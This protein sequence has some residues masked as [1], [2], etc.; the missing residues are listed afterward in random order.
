MEDKNKNMDK[1]LFFKN[2]SYYRSHDADI[3][4][5]RENE[6]EFLVNCCGFSTY[7]FPIRV[8]GTRRDY[9][10]LYVTEGTLN[11]T[12]PYNVTLKAGDFIIFSPDIEF[13]YASSK[14]AYYWVHF[15]GRAANG[16]LHDSYCA[17]RKR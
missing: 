3:D 9:Y 16:I 12:R 7:G 4:N 1:S 17:T 5:H 15:S 14:F 11:V 2:E 8:S 10:F 13:E 6:K